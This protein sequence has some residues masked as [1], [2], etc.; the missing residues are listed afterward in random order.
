MQLSRWLFGA[1]EHSDDSESENDSGGSEDA[2]PI[3]VPALLPVPASLAKPNDSLC[4]ICTAL[5]LTPRRFVV[6]PGDSDAKRNKPDKPTMKLGLVKNIKEQSTSCPFCRLVLKAISNGDI[7]EVEKGEAVSV[8]MS[9]N[10]TGPYQDADRPSRHT[11]LIRVLRLHL[12]TQSGGYVD[13]KTLNAFPEIKLLANDAP[14][15]SKSYFARLIGDEIDFSMVRN[16][17]ALCRV[18]HGDACNQSKTL[19]HSISDP[20]T[21]IPSFRLIDVVNNCIIPAPHRCK[22]VGLSYVW[23]NINPSS[24]L[25]LLK[26]NLEDLEKP[27]SLARK[28]HY[29]KI[30]LTIRDAM[31]VV[32][33]LHLKYLWTDSLCIV[34][35]DEDDH[36][37]KFDA[38]SKMDLVYGAAYL[39]IVAATGTDANAGLPGLHSA[40]RGVTQPVEELAPGF[41]LVSE[42]NSGDYRSSVY[43]T[44]G[45]T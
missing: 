11:P 36:G 28:E 1:G 33:S 17:L 35:D 25:R 45:W 43:Y 23:G 14:T 18:R 40:S 29:E 10:T 7:P 31:Q 30:P 6:L 41:R 21:E 2:E 27:G 5:E 12:Q 38:I 3:T 26:A 37:S 24:I 34:Q 9:W 44:R 15:P 42:I 32:K 8:T 22:Y 20:A 13:I 19:D 39:T 16:W 4:E